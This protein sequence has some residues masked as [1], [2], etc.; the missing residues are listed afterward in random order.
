[1]LVRRLARQII[2]MID[3]GDKQIEEELATTL[4][5]ILHGATPLERV[6]RPNNKRKIVRT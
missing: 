4:H 1:M 2:H 6:A 3:H 5:L